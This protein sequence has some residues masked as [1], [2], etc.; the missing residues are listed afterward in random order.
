MTNGKAVGVLLALGVFFCSS[1]LAQT[2]NGRISGT[3]KDGTGGL[4]PGTPVTI[5]DTARGISRNLTADE[6]GAYLAANLLPGTYTVRAM[7]QG[8]QTWVRENIRLEVGQ[9][10]VIDI[11]LQPGAQE[12]TVTITEEVPLVNVTSATLGGTLSNQS[13]VDLPLNGRN[14]TSLLAMRPGVVLALGNNSGGAGAAAANGLRPEQS[15]E[16]LVEGLHGMSPF[17][18]QPVMNSIAL[19]GDAA[20][21]L[22]VDAIQEFSTQQNTKAE[23]GWKAGGTINIGLKSGTN[24]W[25]GTGYGFFRR[26]ALDARNYFNKSDQPKVNAAL[27]QYG[28]TLGAPI[29]KDKLFFF[30]GFEQQ[31]VNVGDPSA[32]NVP[33]TDPAMIANFPNCITAAGGCSPIPNTV[34]GARTPDASNHMILACLGLPAAS[35][36][37]QS[38][39]L[40]GLNPNCTPGANYPK[41]TSG[42]TWFV[43]H[44]GNDHGAT[45]NPAFGMTSYFANSQ[46]VVRNLGSVGKVD[47]AFN[48]RNAF[49]GFF[50]RGYGDDTYAQGNAVNP[51]WRTRVGAWSLM[52]AGTWSWLPSTAWS[53]SL[54]VGYAT[55]RHRYVGVDSSSGVTAAS[56]GLPTG[57]TT[58]LD[59]N[60]GFP[61]SLAL[62]GFSAIGSRNTEIEGPNNSVEI[63]DQVNFLH[64]PHNVR[65]GGTVMT[66]HQNGGTW[67][68]TKGTFGFGQAANGEGSGNGLMAFLAGQNPIV[69]NTPNSPLGY[70][71]TPGV[72]TNGQCV[73]AAPIRTTT[74]GLETA[75]LFYGN[76]ESH[77][78]RNAYSFFLQD[79]WRVHPRLMLNVGMRYEL[80]EVPH[81]RNKILGSF[82]PNK[83]LVQ[84]GIQIDRIFK[85]DHNNF[86]PRFGFAW[87]ARGNGKTVIRAGGSIIY[88]MVILRTFSEVGNAPGLAGNQTAWVIGCSQPTSA[89]VPAGASTN[90]PGTLITSGGTRDV[91]QIAW[92]RS[93]GTL[94]NIQWDGPGNRTVFPAAAVHNCSPNVR[95]ADVISST[96]SPGR[97]GAPCPVN[98]VDPNLRTPYVE[99]WTLSIEHALTNNLAVDIAYVGNHGV[100]LLGR[101]EDNQPYAGQ[102]WNTVTANG[103]TFAQLC[104]STRA[105][106][107]CDG[108]GGVFGAAVVASKQYATKYPYINT[109]LRLANGMTSNYNGLQVSVTARNFHG[110]NSNVGYT[111]SKALDVNSSN[112]GNVGTDSY[113]LGLDYGR[114]ASDLRQRLTVSNSFSIPDRQG[115][116]QLM[117]GWKINTIYGIS[118]GRPW[119]AG[120]QWGDPGGVGRNSRP[121][122]FGK[123]SDFVV[124]YRGVNSPVF[125]PAGATASGINPQTQNPYTNADLA[126]NTPVC[127]T[128]TRSIATLQAF[129]C[130]TQG[131]SAFI[132]AP[133]GSF[134]NMPK[135]LLDG[136]SFWDVDLSLAKKQQITE[137]VSAE[138]RA[139]S[140]N[141]F[142]HPA[143]AQPA[144][145]VTCSATTCNLGLVSATPDVAATNPVLGSGGARRFQFGVKLIF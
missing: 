90:C 31:R 80:T 40:A 91:G 21:L 12:Q 11:V 105:S 121:D 104:N 143:F 118:T 82:D 62:N 138:F 46:S 65:F 18:G 93:D 59:R 13:I 77:M 54:R 110:F 30:F 24:E 113:N 98:S 84:E 136:P 58:F 14:F 25:H 111:Y 141:I 20:T 106:G 43:P 100:K 33:F 107:N 128:N 26:D 28:L 120:T 68:N 45:A 48:D 19:R 119:Q 95:V 56:L 4:I 16:Y 117:Q 88:E 102:V 101:H 66:G 137:S 47:Y 96:A 73:G 51:D 37:P 74:S 86:G 49:N 112:G 38:L 52:V 70:C 72:F 83:G 39:A 142:N 7:F 2:A 71:P 108:S 123:P 1:A 60:G 94:G 35:R 114:A 63:S 92:T 29:K 131:G 144:S 124:D 134:G 27:N 76:P 87:D 36:S 75:S 5:T 78:R 85:G 67:A 81:D 127:S 122:F 6:G 3:V 55:L 8:F 116:G 103:Q 53:N 64:G 130:W 10:I 23:Y 22:P 15:N 42:A 139:E 145:G 34:A 79:D 50:F 32:A 126:I 99:T 44:G 9:D 61:Q 69:D 140:F 109:V 125:H 89:T 57:V 115:F 135:G 132:P 97:V 41:A 129:G 17:N 133:A